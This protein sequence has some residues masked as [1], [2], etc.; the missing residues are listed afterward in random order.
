MRISLRPRSFPFASNGTCFCSTPCT[1]FFSH[2]L[3]EYLSYQR[4]QQEARRPHCRLRHGLF[5]HVYQGGHEK[6]GNKSNHMV[7]LMVLDFATARIVSME[8]CKSSSD[9]NAI[10]FYMTFYV[11]LLGSVGHHVLFN[12][13]NFDKYAPTI[14]YSCNVT[15][16]GVKRLCLNEVVYGIDAR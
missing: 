2:L 8:P 3:T 1:R 13:P 11:E 9:E 14:D 5:S 6:I 4:P 15:I 12:L 16:K 7:Q 10:E